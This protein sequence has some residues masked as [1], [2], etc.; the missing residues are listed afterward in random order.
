MKQRPNP[1][2]SP[3]FTFGISGQP[4]KIN[5]LEL[6]SN[7]LQRFQYTVEQQGDELLINNSLL[8]LPQIVSISIDSRRTLTEVAMQTSAKNGSWTELFEIQRGFA[9]GSVDPRKVIQDSFD[10]WIK[11]DL[12]ALLDALEEVP[13]ECMFMEITAP[14]GA[15]GNANAFKRRIIFGPVYILSFDQ[16]GQ[17]DEINTRKNTDIDT[18]NH[19]FAPVVFL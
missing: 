4:Q 3:Y 18:K 9:V 10:I 7:S 14:E 13:Q 8:V 16:T 11:T 15:M 12:L 6:L 2:K 1:G 19:E 17:K 5:L